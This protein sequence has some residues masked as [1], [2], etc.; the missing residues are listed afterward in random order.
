MD[1]VAYGL[2]AS[3]GRP[4]WQVPVGLASAFG[5]VAIEGGQAAAL[6]HDA[7]FQEL[8]KVDADTRSP[9]VAARD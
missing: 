4:L 3:D 2:A 9:E 1:G 7:R 5:P 8:V 6:L